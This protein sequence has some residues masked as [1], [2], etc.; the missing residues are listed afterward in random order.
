MET[1]HIPLLAQDPPATTFGVYPWNAQIMAQ[2]L[3]PSPVPVQKHN[4]EAKTSPQK[5][6]RLDMHRLIYSCRALARALAW[7]G[8]LAIIVLSIVPAIDRPVTGAGQ[9][10]EHFTA[11]GLVAAMFAVGYRLSLVQFVVLALIFCG[12]VELLQILLPT[13]H[14]RL[15]DFAVDFVAS[16][17][18]IGCVVASE[19]LLRLSG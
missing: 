4:S 11:F 19:K 15:S 10:A 8:I 3:V 2:G 12:G 9:W 6:T 16:C 18:A 1:I 13:R 7:V 17:F 14:A 5:S